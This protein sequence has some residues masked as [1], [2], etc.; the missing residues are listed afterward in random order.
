VSML[1]V[2][3]LAVLLLSLKQKASSGN[4]P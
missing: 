4:E 1:K 2:D 3:L